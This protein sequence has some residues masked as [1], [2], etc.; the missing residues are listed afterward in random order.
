M[1]PGRLGVASRAALSEGG[2]LA[3]SLSAFAPRPAQQDLSV[4][5]ADAFEARGK[6]GRASCRERVL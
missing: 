3:R 6:I 2:D 1:E 5:I 4:A